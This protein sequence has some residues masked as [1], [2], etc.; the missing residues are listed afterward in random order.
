MEYGVA[1]LEGKGEGGG[2]RRRG[3]RKE[4]GEAKGEGGGGREASALIL[5]SNNGHFAKRP[6]WPQALPG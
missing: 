3:R 6:I 5:P 4:K 2:E 1:W